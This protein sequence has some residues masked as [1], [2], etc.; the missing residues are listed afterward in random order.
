[1]WLPK[2]KEL[3]LPTSCTLTCEGCGVWPGRTPEIIEDMPSLTQYQQG[4]VHITGGDPLLHNKLPLM[5]QTLKQQGNFIILTTPGIRLSLLPPESLRLIDLF[6]LYMPGMDH[7]SIHTATGFD[8]YAQYY[9]TLSSLAEQKRKVLMTYPLVPD[10]IA[11]L[12]DI[13]A[14]SLRLKHYLFLTHNRL[15]GS[16]PRKHVAY[17][18]QRP[19]VLS[20]SCTDGQPKT[21]LGCP[22]KLWR[23][24]PLRLG[25][26]LQGFYKLY[27]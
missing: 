2:Y 5:L 11:T 13:Y 6:F 20:F 19:T 23:V 22:Q 1:M 24:H 8:V 9:L 10:N 14:L 7:E 17:Y 25:A 3:I 4:I 21:C 15:S 12:P 18:R 26:L 27:L 16:L